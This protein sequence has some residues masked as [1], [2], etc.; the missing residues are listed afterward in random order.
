MTAAGLLGLAVPAGCSSSTSSSGAPA[1]SAS[2]STVAGKKMDRHARG[3]VSLMG[4]DENLTL[5]ILTSLSRLGIISSRRRESVAR[6]L[7]ARERQ[8]DE[9]VYRGTR[10]GDA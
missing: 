1:S 3:F 9:R 6:D 10:G 7:R 5:P 4:V 2:A 8:H